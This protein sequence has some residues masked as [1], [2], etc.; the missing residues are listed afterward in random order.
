LSPGPTFPDPEV[1]ISR[2]PYNFVRNPM[3]LGGLTVLLGWGLYKL[4]VTTVIFAVVMAGLMHLFVML[5][6]EPKLERRFGGSYRSYKN[7]V[8]RWIPSRRA[9]TAQ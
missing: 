8:N 4:S 2:G 1:F 3:G 6:E 5:V 7:R 9:T